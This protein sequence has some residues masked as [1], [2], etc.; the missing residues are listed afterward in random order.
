[1]LLVVI[2]LDPAGD[3]IAGDILKSFRRDFGIEDIESLQ[4]RAYHR[5]GSRV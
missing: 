2:D 4:G 1:M 5:T 3:A